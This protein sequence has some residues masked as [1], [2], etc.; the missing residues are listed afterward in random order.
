MPRDIVGNGRM[1]FTILLTNTCRR[2]IVPALMTVTCSASK[3]KGIPRP[4]EA[5]DRLRVDEIPE[6]P[7][8][9]AKILEVEDPK[10]RIHE[11]H[12]HEARVPR[13]MAAP[14]NT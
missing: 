7:E 9:R 12:E 1:F 6:E 4:E 8:Y 3:R 5:V 2:M 13:T 11:D 14:F 10:S